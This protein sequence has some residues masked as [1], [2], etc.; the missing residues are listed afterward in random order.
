MPRIRTIKPKFWDDVKVSKLSRD[1]RLLYI[2]MWNFSDD[3]GVI[4]SDSIWLKS[5]IFPFDNIQVQQFDK[6][7]QELVKP[8]FISPLSHNGEGFYYLPNLTR[9]QVINRP[10][11]EDVFID[12]KTLKRLLNGSFSENHGTINEQSVQERRGKERKGRERSGVDGAKKNSPPPLSAVIEFFKEKGF[13][14]EL[15]KKAFDYYHAGEWK[16]GK[17]KPVLNWKQKMISVWMKNDQKNEKHGK[18]ISDRIANF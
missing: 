8:G 3:T 18:T 9:H 15:A 1:A 13:S 6:W 2:G 12:E 7:I 4:I 17:G 10:N 11:Y 14:E 5:K 16:D